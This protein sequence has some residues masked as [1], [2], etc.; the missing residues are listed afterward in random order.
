MKL[1]IC[2]ACRLCKMHSLFEFEKD[3]TD[4][5]NKVMRWT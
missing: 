2:H 4:N 3:Y 1:C 5:Y